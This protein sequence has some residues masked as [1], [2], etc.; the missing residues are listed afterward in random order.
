[1]LTP[2]SGRVRVAHDANAMEG[3][4]KKSYLTDDPK[5]AALLPVLREKL[6]TLQSSDP[7]ATPPLSPSPPPPS[8]YFES[9]S[10][11][12]RSSIVEPFDLNVASLYQVFHVKVKIQSRGRGG[13]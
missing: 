11:S 13:L 12:S 4:L 5:H 2:N 10:I 8:L 6:R 7:A 9:S 3:K 1:M